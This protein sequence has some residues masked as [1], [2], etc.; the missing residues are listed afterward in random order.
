[1]YRKGFIPFA[2]DLNYSPTSQTMQGYLEK[3]GLQCERT[4]ILPWRNH[5]GLSAAAMLHRKN[6]LFCHPPEPRK[7]VSTAH[8]HG[9]GEAHHARGPADFFLLSLEDE[10]VAAALVF[11]VADG[12]VQV[13]YWGDLPAHA[14]NKCMNYLAYRLGFIT[15]KKVCGSLMGPST[16]KHSQLRVMPF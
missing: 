13:I 12:I 6:S 2:S 7:R 16:E 1:M 5:S 9:S 10:P 3:P 15:L 14:A 4:C 8:D 11:Y